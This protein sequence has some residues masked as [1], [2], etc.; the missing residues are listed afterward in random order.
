M[1]NWTYQCYV[2]GKSPNLW[3]RWYDDHPAARGAHDAAF[4]ILEQL[5]AWRGSNAKTFDDIV[6]VKFKGGGL[7][8]RIFGFYPKSGIRQRFVVTGTGYH[9]GKQYTPKDILNTCS[10]RRKEIEADASKAVECTRP[11]TPTVPGEGIS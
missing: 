11:T 2:D 3:Q 9:K 7:Q 5:E 6:E 1:A 4:D 10:S 8:H